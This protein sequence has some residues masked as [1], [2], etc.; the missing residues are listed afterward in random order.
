MADGGLARTEVQMAQKCTWPGSEEQRDSVVYHMLK[1]CGVRAR[2][3]LRIGVK[4]ISLS[5][6][7]K[8]YSDLK[9]FLMLPFPNEWT[10]SK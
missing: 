10:T 9:M 1:S 2:N 7:Q 6:P 8:S 3:Y 5:R 4:Y